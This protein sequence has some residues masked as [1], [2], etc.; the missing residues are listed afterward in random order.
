VRLPAL[1]DSPPAAPTATP[2]VGDL[3]FETTL[4][5]E[6]L[7]T[8]SRFAFVLVRVTVQPGTRP[9]LRASDGGCCP[10]PV[11]DYVLAGTDALRTDGPVQVV[12]AGR[13]GML[14]AVPA[15]TQVSLRPGDT[16]VHRSESGWEVTNPGTTPLQLLHVIL[17]A[18]YVPDPPLGWD[19]ADYAYVFPD[20][21]AP[22][23][24]LVVSLRRATLAPGDTVPGARPGDMQAV[25]AESGPGLLDRGSDGSARIIGREATVVYILTLH[26]TGS[27]SG[28]PAAGTAP[29]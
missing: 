15:G 23:G 22:N 28:T 3:L 16:V 7:P 2:G 9:V 29:P 8:G 20:P 10:G 1:T 5:T 14:E 18:H 13:S 24:P 25:V 26:P 11:V 12:R 21:T 27:T 4:P 17:S 19:Y 6:A